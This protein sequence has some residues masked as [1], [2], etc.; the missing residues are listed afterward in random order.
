ME[1]LEYKKYKGLENIITIDLH[2]GYT[3][4]AI[5]TFDKETQKYI[6]DL[7]LN[8]NQIDN[9][10]PINSCQNIMI[11]S[12]RNRINSMILKQV[13]TLLHEKCFDS[14]IQKYKYETR[15]FDIGNT[16]LEKE[17]LCGN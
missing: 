12:N 15:C 11:E 17:R 2:N 6:V 9:W 10:K 8:D 3:I 16:E 7:F 4:A 1:R 14:D 13:A 5:R